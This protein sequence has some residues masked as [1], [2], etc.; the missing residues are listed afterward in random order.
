[1]MTVVILVISAV[2]FH[3]SAKDYPLFLL[4]MTAFIVMP[5]RN[6]EKNLLK[7]KVFDILT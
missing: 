3:L 4:T 1:M 6:V 7:E 2:G 5:N